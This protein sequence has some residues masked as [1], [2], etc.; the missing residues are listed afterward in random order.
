MAAA[1]VTV[2]VLEGDDPAAILAAADAVAQ[3][4]APEAAAAD[5]DG[6]FRPAS[7]EALWRAGLGNLTLASRL[8][9]SGATLPTVTEAVA[10]IGAVDPST[11]LVWVMH[12]LQLQLVSEPVDVWP[13]ELRDEIVA[14]TLAG[15]ALINALSVEPDLGSAARGGRPA[16]TAVRVTGADGAPAWRLS[17]HKTFCTGS[18]GLRWLV[19]WASAQDESGP[20]TGAFF[21][22]A[23]TPGI[24]IRET[25]DHVGLRATASHDVIL[26]DVVVPPHRVVGLAPADREQPFRSGT[27]V[28]WGVALLAA[29]YVGVGRATRTA[30]TT[31]LREHVPASLGTSLAT[32][33]RVQAIV[34][35]IEAELLIA[36]TLTHELAAAGERGGTEAERASARATLVKAVVTRAV[37]AATD[38]ALDA[39][40]DAGLAHHHPLQRHHRDALCGPVHTPQTDSV[41]TAAGRAALT[42]VTPTERSHDAR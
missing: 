35:E 36:E 40:G 17:G 33:P 22:R 8:G 23:D 38:R 18:V 30:L 34:G 41:L 12:L 20:L 31:Y 4:I 39:V 21:V 3:V 16:T 6:R 27:F 32:L 15:P 7:V 13:D 10:R 24:E 1:G 29:I 14:G 2:P 37:L 11:A 26:H 9:G 25:W 19:V 28:V 42:P 5:R